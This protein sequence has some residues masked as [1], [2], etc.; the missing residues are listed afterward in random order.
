MHVK[1]SEAVDSLQVVQLESHGKH[2]LSF[3]TK[4]RKEKL[5]DLKFVFA[6]KTNLCLRMFHLDKQGFLHCCISNIIHCKQ[7]NKSQILHEKK[8]LNEQF[9]ES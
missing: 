4:K 1:Q 8:Q 3:V 9:Y 7:C 2:L 5:K 6:K